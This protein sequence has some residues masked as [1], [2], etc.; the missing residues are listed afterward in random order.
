MH[1]HM[2]VKVIKKYA[3][4]R[5]EEAVVSSATESLLWVKVK[6]EAELEHNFHIRINVQDVLIV[7]N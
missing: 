4:L 2:N 7:E 6:I 5:T 1:G 3:Y